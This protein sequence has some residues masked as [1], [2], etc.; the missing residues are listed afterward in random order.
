MGESAALVNSG[1]LEGSVMTTGG[2][3]TLE[4]AF[5]ALQAGII[6]AGELCRIGQ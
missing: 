6:T 4:E 5:A 1:L 3:T 2:I